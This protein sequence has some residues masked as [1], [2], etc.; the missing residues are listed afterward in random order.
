MKNLFGSDRIPRSGICGCM[1]AELYAQHNRASKGL[2]LMRVKLVQIYKTKHKLQ[3]WSEI[4][5]TPVLAPRPNRAGVPRE[6]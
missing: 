5:V 2:T 3:V 1:C 4:C 6:V